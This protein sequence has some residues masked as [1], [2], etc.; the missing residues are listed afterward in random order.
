MIKLTAIVFF[1]SLMQIPLYAWSGPGHAAVAVM[2]YKELSQSRKK[3]LTE[4]LKKHP[5]G[6]AWIAEFNSKKSGFPKEPNLG[7]YLFIKAATWP[8]VIRDDQDPSTHPNWHFVNY[9]VTL[10]D[11]TTG[12]SPSPEDDVVFG[13]KESLKTL[14]D[15]SNDNAERAA[16][17][18]W[19]IHLVGDAHQP[20]H[21]TALIGEG[22]HLPRG[23]KGG[24]SYLIFQTANQEEQNRTTKL[25]AFWDGRLGTGV[26][27]SPTKA[28]EDAN[29]LISRHKR[30]SLQ[31]LGVGSDIGVWTFESRDTAIANAYKFEGERVRQ[32]T[33]LPN[34]YV[35]NSHKVARR[36]LALAGYRLADEI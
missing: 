36:R 22:F 26:D 8:D 34:G 16:A 33:V 6:E 18:S 7:M 23:D 17:L 14:R 1:I 11:F 29:M 4:L 12:P 13:L 21:C 28:L 27:P 2:A 3:S 35:T 25:H 24:N 30:S 19:I 20:L 15:S 5:D 10:P 9:S 32:R 31:E